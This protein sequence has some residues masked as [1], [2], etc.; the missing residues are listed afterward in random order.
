MSKI[1][2]TDTQMVKSILHN[3]AYKASM[4][5]C[6]WQ[7]WPDAEG[8]FEFACRDPECDLRPILPALREQINAWRGLHM[9]HDEKEYMHS[10]GYLPKGYVEWLGNDFRFD[11]SRASVL[12]NKNK[13]GKIEVI[14]RDKWMSSSQWEIPVLSTISG[15]WTEYQLEQRGVSWDEFLD[16][17]LRIL[18]AK[19]KKLSGYPRITYADFSLRRNAHPDWHIL[20]LRRCLQNHKQISGTS[21]IHLAYKFNMKQIG[22]MAHELFMGVMA[23]IAR[24]E[25]ANQ[26]VLH[27]WLMTYKEM[28]GIAL[29]DTFTTEAFWSDFDVVLA[30]AFDG[31]RHD[32]ACP[33]EFA[34]KTIEFYQN[35]GIAPM[36][37]TIV[38][39]DSLTVDMII[40]LWKN[41]VGLIRCAFG[42]GGGL[43]NDIYPFLKL[44][45]VMKL[46]WLNGKPLCKF[47]DVGGKNM[48]AA[49]GTLDGQRLAYKKNGIILL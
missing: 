5:G 45:I 10:W 16:D 1:F 38:W 24:P 31:L 47:S 2:S 29:T 37:K 32:S 23:L 3:D 4:G 40:D 46:M 15:L 19:L 48:E 49:P 8:V 17:G 12:E 35:L 43:G 27:K 6:I 14:V 41:F 11:P 30:R 33:Y 39:S 22:T 28:L 44:N 36:D 25:M 7:H 9:F 42:W 13:P 26:E 21:A 34:R 18:D 20:M